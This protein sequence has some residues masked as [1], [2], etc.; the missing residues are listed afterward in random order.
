MF[1]PDGLREP[2]AA[3]GVPAPRRPPRHIRPRATVTHHRIRVRAAVATLTV[4]VPLFPPARIDAG[5]ASLLAR[6]ACLRSDLREA[7]PRGSL[8]VSP[9]VPLP[10]S[11]PVVFHRVCYADLPLR[12]L[13]LLYRRYYFIL[14]FITVLYYYSIYIRIIYLRSLP[15]TRPDLVECQR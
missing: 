14:L 1:R 7:L 10:L 4:S 8:A 2:T 11:L 15:Q 6:L 3:C 9:L 12:V 5:A 13:L